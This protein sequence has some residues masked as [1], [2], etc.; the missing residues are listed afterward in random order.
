MTVV[1]IVIRSI[2]FSHTLHVLQGSLRATLGPP[3]PVSPVR[4]RE[5]FNPKPYPTPDP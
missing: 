1:Q 5:G 3:A 2:G 4:S